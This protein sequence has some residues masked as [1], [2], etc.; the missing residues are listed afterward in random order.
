[1]AALTTPLCDLL[2]IEVPIIQ[3]PMAGG[4]TTPDLVSAVCN[5]GALGSFG[6]AYTQ[7]EAMQREVEIVRARTSGPFNLNLFLSEDAGAI[8]ASAQQAALA[9]VAPYFE[10]LGL[11]AP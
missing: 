4:T 1:M 6:F 5:A 7:P 2:G 9:A 3:A 11:K 8:D 10:E